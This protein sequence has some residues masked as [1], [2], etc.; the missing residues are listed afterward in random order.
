MLK[1]ISNSGLN[2]I[3]KMVTPTFIKKMILKLP[4]NQI[5]Q[6]NLTLNLLGKSYR[7]EGEVPGSHAE[8]TLL[9]P[10]RAYWLMKTQG[11]LGFAQAYFEDAVETHSLYHLMH[12]V[13]QNQALM[14]RLLAN[15]TFNLWHL[16][17]HR[18]RH[19]SVE[20]S[21]KNISYHY[22]LGNKFYQAWLDQTMSYSSGLFMDGSES[23]AQSQQQKYQ[24][25]L[26]ELELKGGEKILEIGCG[27]GGFMEAALQ[28]GASV[29]GLTLSTEQRDFAL[30]RLQS[31]ASA[32]RFEVA[33]QD[34]RHETLQY[35]HI[36]SIEMFEAVGEAY[37]DTYFEQLN[38]CLKPN[39]KAALQVI[40]INEAFAEHYQS[41]VDF[42]QTYIF[43]GGLLPSLTQLKQLASK[44]GFKVDNVLDF[45]QNYAKT[46]Q[47]WKQDF[48]QHS[49]ALL[50]LGYDRQFQKMWNYYLDYCT[51][52]FETEHSSVVQLTLTKVEQV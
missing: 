4:F 6:G 3:G 42:I 33:L 18:K 34:Y 38:H 52:G 5:K 26:D 29:K 27:W 19:N 44:H 13:Y 7:F 50:S 43:P 49:D 40:T 11:E 12:L 35:D 22:D 30:Q 41:N 51:V 8:L 28:K 32:D 46:C 48:N 23:L 47:L 31:H 15:T 36:V 37:W 16:W 21:R 25:L 45:G 2:L 20:N 10:F 9:K 39:G 17:Q 14:D 24:R 1:A